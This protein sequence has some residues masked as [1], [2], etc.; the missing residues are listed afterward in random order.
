MTPQQVTEASSGTKLGS[1]ALPEVEALIETVIARLGIAARYKPARDVQ[2]YMAQRLYSDSRYTRDQV[3]LAVDGY[4]A[5]ILETAVDKTKPFGLQQL[6]RLMYAYS[7]EAQRIAPQRV[8]EQRTYETDKV[9]NAQARKETYEQIREVISSGKEPRINVMYLWQMAY[10]Y[11]LEQGM[12]AKEEFD[13]AY[14][15]GK[16]DYHQFC[17]Q[18]G[19]VREMRGMEDVRLADSIGSRQAKIVVTNGI[20]RSL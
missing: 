13:A 6:N 20:R 15:Q 7:V 16:Q 18:N 1:L 9:R 2:A 10:R 14:E 17:L 11:M 8:T 12:V 5:G 4:N 3:L 19:R